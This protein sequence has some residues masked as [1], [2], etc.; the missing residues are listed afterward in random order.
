MAHAERWADAGRRPFT[1]PLT[2]RAIALAKA[3]AVTGRVRTE[4]LGAPLPP[5]ARAVLCIP[6]GVTTRPQNHNRVVDEVA[7]ALGA[8]HASSIEVAGGC[9][10]AAGMA[11]LLDGWDMEGAVD[12]A[13]FAARRGIPFGPRRSK[14]DVVAQI[15]RSIDEV[16]DAG[17]WSPIIADSIRNWGA[18]EGVAPL[19]LALAYAHRGRVVD[20]LAVAVRE[21]GP[22]PIGMLA[23]ALCAAYRPEEIPD[24]EAQSF[25]TLAEPLLDIRFPGWS[26]N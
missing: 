1:T 5:G 24:A 4:C 17:G 18:G 16:D 23:A 3:I 19:A 2:D 13:L 26:A 20:A 8:M 10:V 9:A 12:L 21:F 25:E 15:R 6:I 7:T 11:A 22:G 14:V